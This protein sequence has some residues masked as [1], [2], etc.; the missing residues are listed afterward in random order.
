MCD[1]YEPLHFFL[2][3]ELVMA[4]FKEPKTF[5]LKYLARDLGVGQA[6]LTRA[7]DLGKKRFV[8][9]V[10]YGRNDRGLEQVT[11]QPSDRLIKDLEAAKAEAKARFN[12]SQHAR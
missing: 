8:L 7:I 2:V 10:E 9:Y 5:T 4:S 11:V 12:E 6:T 3:R 1:A